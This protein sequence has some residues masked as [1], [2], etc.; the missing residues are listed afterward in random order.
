MDPS[1]PRFPKPNNN[2]TLGDIPGENYGSLPGFLGAPEREDYLRKHP[3]GYPAMPTPPP[4]PEGMD[5]A[6]VRRQVLLWL[7]GLRCVFEDRFL[8]DLIAATTTSW[9]KQSWSPSHLP[10]WVDPTYR[11]QAIGGTATATI[12]AGGAWTNVVSGTVP[13][14]YMG[15]LHQIG[16]DMAE[17]TNSWSSLTW[18]IAADRAS[19]PTT[20][21][22][23]S[24]TYFPFAYQLGQ[25]EAP[26]PIYGQMIPEGYTFALQASNASLAG[27]GVIGRIEGWMWP[28]TGGV[29]DGAAGSIVV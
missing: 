1:D 14:G 26:T 24:A 15:V 3:G 11:S 22:H 13:I 16:Q 9:R 12:P 8:M 29:S 5:P 7:N 19:T 23:G 21:I 25:I 10:P 17:T 2:G 18:R 27:I 4:F 6:L 28:R 20:P